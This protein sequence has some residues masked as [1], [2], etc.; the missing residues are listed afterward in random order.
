MRAGT[1]TLGLV[2]AIRTVRAT[3]TELFVVGGGAE[4]SC[5]TIL[6]ELRAIGTVLALIARGLVQRRETVISRGTELRCH[7][8][9][10]T[11]RR[12]IS[13]FVALAVECCRTHLRQHDTGAAAVQTC[14]TQCGGRAHPERA[15]TTRG[16]R[17]AGRERTRLREIQARCHRNGLHIGHETNKSRGTVLR[18]I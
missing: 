8:A 10:G 9:L 12:E 18:R 5:G 16:T 6:R 4:I 3:W 14:G 13:Q 7:R 15:I 1:L 17:G 11:V 2:S